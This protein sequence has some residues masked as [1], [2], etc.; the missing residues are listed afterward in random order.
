MS[1]GKLEQCSVYLTDQVDS[2]GNKKPAAEK[3]EMGAYDSEKH[4]VGT[5]Y[6]IHSSGG[7]A[8]GLLGVMKNGEIT[9]SFASVPIVTTENGIA[10][11]LV[12]ENTGNQSSITHS[13]TGGYTKSGYYEQYFGVAALGGNG[14]AGGFIGKDTAAASIIKNSY[15]TSSVYGNVSGGF[16]GMTENGV[17]TYQ[18]SYATGKVEG[19]S[20]T[21]KKGA[22]IGAITE[23]YNVSAQQCY[24]LEQSNK[25]LGSSVNGILALGYE[26]LKTAT[27]A[28]GRIS[29]QNRNIST[30]M[31]KESYSYDTTLKDEE[32]PFGLVTS[33]GAKVA[34]TNRVHYGD[35]PLEEEQITDEIGVVYYEI[36]ENKLYYHGYLGDFSA[37]ESQPNYR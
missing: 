19:V 9:D 8:G 36:I 17:K 2:Y 34:D 16:T 5:K 24:Y 32:Y 10:G 22:F 4:S 35:W 6:M 21:S 37:N 29:S 15:S 3:Y 18:N 13:Y 12:G 31:N 33:T 20:D 11:G 27:A 7:T 30:K 25:G 26:E 14:V 28:F 23:W 1:S